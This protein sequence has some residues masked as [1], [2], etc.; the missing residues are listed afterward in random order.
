MKIL[1]HGR[2]YDNGKPFV[3]NCNCGC[4]VQVER[5]EITKMGK[6]GWSCR[7]EEYTQFFWGVICPECSSKVKIEDKRLSSL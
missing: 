4:T 7:N 3:A 6:P 2:Y 5:S 1:N